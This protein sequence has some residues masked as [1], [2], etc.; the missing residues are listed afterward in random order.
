[1]PYRRL[2]NTDKARVKAMKIALK[3]QEDTIEIILPFEFRKK[4]EEV[5]QNFEN[6]LN[7]KNATQQKGILNNKKHSENTQKSRMYLSHFMQVVNM[8]IQRGELSSDI[9]TFYGIDKEDSKLP[10]L[11]SEQ[12]L[13]EW[14]KK[15]IEGE[16]ERMQ[17]RGN[18]IHN[19][20]IALVSI[21]Y[22]KF[23]ESYKTS[24]NQ[25]NISQ[26]AN[27]DLYAYREIADQYILELWNLLEEYFKEKSPKEFHQKCTD[28][29]I[30]YVYRKG[31]LEKLEKE[32]YV[33]SISPSLNF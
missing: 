15:V 16:N 18:R 25:K 13:L 12:M 14:G 33:N 31:E 9:R 17:Q 10:D 22:E 27:S 11:S 21:N 23:V 19:P 28:W 8:C 6:K 32:R 7:F 30:S 1:M 26:R 3:K 24:Q 5:A 29:G 4:L 20:S 2:P